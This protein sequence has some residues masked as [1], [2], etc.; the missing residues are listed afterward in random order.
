MNLHILADP[1]PGSQNV[2]D[3][4]HCNKDKKKK[5]KFFFLHFIT[6][7]EEILADMDPFFSV[8]TADLGSAS[9]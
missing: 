2:V 9:G 7:L 1:D 5:K 4:K 3:P 6:N 8:R